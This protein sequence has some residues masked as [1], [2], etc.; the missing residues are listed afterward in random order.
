M[1]PMGFALPENYLFQPWNSIFFWFDEYFLFEGPF[2]EVNCEFQEGYLFS[3][4]D[5]Q[6]PWVFHAYK[7]LSVKVAPPMTRSWKVVASSKKESSAFDF[8]FSGNCC[9]FSMDHYK[10]TKDD[11]AFG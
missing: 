2:S 8:I 6:N 3:E 7:F 11:D 5:P 4:A 9:R 1:D 10:T